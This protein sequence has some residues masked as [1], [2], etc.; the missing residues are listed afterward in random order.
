[1]NYW[2]SVKSKKPIVQRDFR[3]VN[4]L[5][6]FSI[7]DSYATESVNLSSSKFPALTT[8]LG[9]SLLGSGFVNPITGVGAWKDSELQAISSGTWYKY[10][11]GAWTGVTGGTVLGTADAS[12]ANFKGGFADI[13]LIMANG[14]SFKK[15]DGA[16]VS[17]LATA[18]AGGNYV[19]QFADRLWC[20][21]GNDLKYTAYRV[22]DDWTTIN[23]DDADSGFITVETANGETINSVKAGLS[24]MTVFKPSSIH[25][26]MGYAPSDYTLIPVTREI[27]VLNNKCAVTIQG[28]MYILDDTGL[29]Q[30]YGSTLP[31][32]GFSEVVQYYIDNM[33]ASASSVASLTSDGRYLYVSIPLLG[34]TTDTML[35]YDTQFKIWNVYTGVS[36][37]CGVKMGNTLYLGDTTGKVVTMDGTA[38]FGSPIPFKWVSKPFGSGSMHQRIRWYRMALVVDV[39]VGSTLTVYVSKSATGDSDWTSVQT[40]TGALQSIRMPVNLGALAMGNWLRVKF[41]GTGPVSIYEWDREQE[42]MPWR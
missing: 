42:E 33:N 23:G 5:D 18:P 7:G 19:E 26:L 40:I 25:K 30:Y 8:R 28:V 41:E 14:T 21:V 35:V 24:A 34:A 20:A 4:K 15:Y 36:P 6:S 17:N 39:A 1:M 29:Y 3:G 16:T 38:D 12:F 27:G 9:F 11:G 10:S 22:G 2:P 13:N 32:K 31:D 37:S